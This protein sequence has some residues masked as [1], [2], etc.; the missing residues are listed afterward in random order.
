MLNRIKFHWSAFWLKR[1]YESQLREVTARRYELNRNG[2]VAQQ[3]Q[4]IHEQYRI[5]YL[6][7]LRKY[8]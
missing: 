4:A 8:S 5:D 2:L 7:L 3:R 1:R 6:N